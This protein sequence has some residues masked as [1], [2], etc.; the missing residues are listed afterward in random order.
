MTSP[1]LTGPQAILCGLRALGCT[2]KQVRAGAARFYDLDVRSD[3][4]LESCFRKSALCLPWVPGCQ[5]GSEP[6]LSQWEE[7]RLCAEIRHGADELASCP[8]DYILNYAHDLKIQ[9]VK[10]AIQF[11]LNLNCPRLAA[12]LEFPS[13]PPTPSW[14]AD[15]A[16]RNSLRIRC[17][18]KLDSVR[19]KFC[20]RATI[21]NWFYQNSQVLQSYNS[22]LILNM[23]ET[24]LSTNR[25]FRVVVPDDM[26]PIVAE[27]RKEIHLTGIVTFSSNGKLFRPGVILPGLKNLPAELQNLTTTCDFYTSQNGWM[28][29]RVFDAFCVNLAHE[30]AIWRLELPNNLRHQRILLIVD[31]HGSRKSAF[32]ICYLLMHGIDVLIFPGHST[33]VMQPFDVAVAAPMKGQLL[34]EIQKRER[35]LADGRIYA[36]SATGARRYIL[37]ESFSEA[38]RKS[39][40]PCACRNAFQASGLRP[41]N[42]NVP[43]SS[44]L[45]LPHALEVHEE[46]WISGAYFSPTSAATRELLQRE[47]LPNGLP[48]LTSYDMLGRCCSAFL[49]TPRLLP[50]AVAIL[51]FETLRPG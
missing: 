47:G 2:Y 23:D 25:K 44:H 5:G 38:I 3:E 43:L 42:A 34:K 19:R 41:I 14:L 35:L 31:G 49:S 24:G 16:H 30:V 51:D 29:K 8:T 18:E 48:N 45:V 1:L 20:D 27:E 7:Q 11:L 4:A 40:T 28:T 17:C 15:F 21:W 50:T 22:D 36:S 12:K 33:H 32:G 13:S 9:R 39:A 26:F 46:D 10:L 6:Y 37:T